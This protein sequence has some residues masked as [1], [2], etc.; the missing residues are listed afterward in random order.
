MILVACGL[1]PSQIF[2]FRACFCNFALGRVNGRLKQHP[3]SRQPLFAALS[4]TAVSAAR[5]VP[6]CDHRSTAPCCPHPTER[7]IVNYD[8]ASDDDIY[9][10]LTAPPVERIERTY[11]LE[12][13]RYSPYL[14]DRMPRV[15]LDTINFDLAS[16]EVEPDQYPKLER[17]AHVMNRIIDRH[18]D[19]MFL[20]E[21][22]TDAVGSDEDNLSLSDRRAETVAEILTKEFNVPPENLST[23][24]YG[25]QFLKIQTPGPERA[26]RRCHPAHHAA[27]VK[28]R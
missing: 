2:E 21:G 16:W 12:E 10:A 4:R 9:F 14:R 23:Q 5:L 17:L 26:N 13:V 22:H 27:L 3:I 6:R 18:P 28:I 15:D 1:L 11:S 25:K 20:V 19:E 7:Y 24:G 8:D